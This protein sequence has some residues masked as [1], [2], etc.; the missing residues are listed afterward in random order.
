MKALI[1]DDKMYT[2][3]TLN[4]QQMKPNFLSSPTEALGV[5]GEDQ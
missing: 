1:I 5:S 3:R 2:W 4:P